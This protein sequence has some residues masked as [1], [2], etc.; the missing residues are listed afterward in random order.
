MNNF[1]LTLPTEIFFGKG[2]VSVLGKTLK[3]EK[4]TKALLAYGHGSIKR[5]G[6]YDDIVKELNEH[7]IPFVELSGIDPNPRIKTV[8]E[9]AK[10]CREEGIDFIIAAGAGSVIDCC[11]A[12]A[13]ARYY[14]GDPWDFFTRRTSIKKALPICTVLTLAAT[15]SEMNGGAVITNEATMEKLSTGS[16]K[17]KPKFSILDPVYTFSVPK[18]QTS[19]GIADIMSHVF[20]QYFSYPDAMLPDFLSEA[21]LKTVI[22]SGPVAVTDPCNYEARADIMWAGTIA[23]NGILGVGKD[24]DWATHM[25]EHELSA[26]Y[27]ITHG[28]GLAILTPHWMRKVL[29]EKNAVKFAEYGKNVWSVQGIDSMDTALQ[30]IDKTAEFF[31][32]VGI[33]SKLSDI[34]I[35]GS[36][37]EE[38]ADS[39]L[40][41]SKIGRFKSLSKQDIIDIYRSSL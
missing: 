31:R 4:C 8:A 34:G 35:D 21:V 39:A 10:I 26:K 36:K 30:A 12:I 2:Q 17:M 40:K 19:A 20:E 7:S 16:M 37:F 24:G 29:D 15:G 11:K 25:I 6:V 28:T 5:N 18:D 13:V 38:M 33:P 3:K 41:Y 32:S 14:S 22:K 1:W 23:L 27:D 9:G